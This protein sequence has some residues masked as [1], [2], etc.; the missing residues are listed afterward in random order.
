M[1]MADAL[2]GWEPPG[3]DLASPAPII[4]VS[5]K[6]WCRGS[7]QAA[8][9]RHIGRGPQNAASTRRFELVEPTGEITSRA[10]KK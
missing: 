4:E 6:T 7:F 5:Q 2:A 1:T 10:D 3:S 8:W 9:P